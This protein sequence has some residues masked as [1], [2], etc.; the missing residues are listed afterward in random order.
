MNQ[1]AAQLDDGYVMLTIDTY[2]LNVIYNLPVT[3]AR[4][5]IAMTQTGRLKTWIYPTKWVLIDSY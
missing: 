2:R 3:Y 5:I 1:Y 4:L